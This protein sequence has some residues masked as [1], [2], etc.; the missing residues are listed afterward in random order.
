MSYIGQAVDYLKEMP[1][2]EPDM[3]YVLNQ[4]LVAVQEAMYGLGISEGT[5]GW[6]DIA[7][8]RDYVRGYLDSGYG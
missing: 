7:F 8:I 4:T 5:P 3:A 2:D 1:E 6:D